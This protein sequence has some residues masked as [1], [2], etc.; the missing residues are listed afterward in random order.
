MTSEASASEAREE[1]ETSRLVDQAVAFLQHP[2]TQGSPLAGRVEF[3]R[4]K[5]LTEAQVVRALQRSGLSP[6]AATLLSAESAAVDGRASSTSGRVSWASWASWLVG[7]AAAVA[8]AL[9]GRTNT[10]TARAQAEAAE[11]SAAALNTQLQDLAV[12]S[13]DVMQQHATKIDKQTTKIDKLARTVDAHTEREEQLKEMLR[14]A[15]RELAHELRQ[16]IRAEL[17]QEIRAELRTSRASC[18][19]CTILHRATRSCTGGVL[20]EPVTSTHAL[21]TLAPRC[22]PTLPACSRSRV[23]T[24]ASII[25]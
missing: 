4:Q 23:S 20:G 5:G 22:L 25:P 8:I 1:E 14:M 21:H 10:A 19:P 7:G 9:E 2:K 6:P 24:S 13:H 17:R 18:A 3:L 12:K 16:E 15:T 11:A